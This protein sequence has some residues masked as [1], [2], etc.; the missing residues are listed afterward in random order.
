L[1]PLPYDDFLILSLEHQI[2]FKDTTELAR[3][4]GYMGHLV[5]E[6]NEIQ[7]H[8]NNFNRDMAFPLMHP[9]YLTTYVATC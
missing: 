4:T 5:K 9:Q 8:P 1:L 7:L 3:T 2:N 6:T